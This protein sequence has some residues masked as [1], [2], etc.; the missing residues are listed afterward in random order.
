[1]NYEKYTE[2]LLKQYDLALNVY[3]RLIFQKVDHLSH[4]Q[5]FSTKE[6]LRLPPREGLFPFCQGDTWGSE[7]E[8]IWLSFDVR[9]TAAYAGK[10]IWLIPHTGAKERNNERPICIHKP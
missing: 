2:K 9:T 3:A 10:Q 4:V 5:A 1:M 8:N 7:W 6:H